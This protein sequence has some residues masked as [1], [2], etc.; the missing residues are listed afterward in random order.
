MSSQINLNN[1]KITA[2][3]IERNITDQYLLCLVDLKQL[4]FAESMM[5]LID[6]QRLILKKLVDASIY[7]QSDLVLLNIESQNF[8][9]LFA[10]SKANYRR[11]LMDL[12]VL[13]TIT[14][15]SLVN[16]QD[17]NL[18][19]LPSIENSAFAEKY[20]LDSMNIRAQQ[21][22]FELKYEPQV[23]AYGNAGL[24]AT[25]VNIWPRRLGFSAGLTASYTLFD[26]NQKN[27]NKS[28]NDIFIQSIN[29]Y[30][31]Q[32][33]TQNALRKAKILKELESFTERTAILEQQIN[34]YKTLLTLYRKEIITGQ[35]SIINYTTALKNMA[36]VQQNFNLLSAQ[37]QS[38]INLYNYWN[39]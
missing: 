13:A 32:F 35:I 28:K 24:N 10:N 6:S 21:R 39:W 16:L 23:F 9:A 4:Q 5:Q 17:L 22:I 8:S 3:D 1:S 2:H 27:I 20:R 30:K 33:E 11:N 37:K 7:K 15:T 38:L 18:V 19:L 36:L 14:D 25:D 34:D 29:F 12:N 31:S 26:G